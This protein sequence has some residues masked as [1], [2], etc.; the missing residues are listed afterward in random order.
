LTGGVGDHSPAAGRDLDGAPGR[1]RQI[2][3]DRP[4]QLGKPNIHGSFRPVEERLA[5]QDADRV[6]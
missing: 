1:I 6:F 2:E 3:I 5:A 4:A